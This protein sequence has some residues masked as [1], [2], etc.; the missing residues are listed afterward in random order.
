MMNISTKK[1]D[2]GE[3]FLANGQSISKADL[4]IEVI[5]D[6][7]ELNSW[8][9]VAVAYLDD[10]FLKDKKLLIKLQNEFFVMGAELAKAKKV[11]LSDQLLKNIEDRSEF[12]QTHLEESEYTKFVLPGGSKQAVWL[13]ISRTVCRRAERNLV[14]LNQVEKIR[15]ILLTTVNR[16]SDYLYVLRCYVNRELG[17]VEKKVMTKKS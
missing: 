8:I 5:G 11:K 10:K 3:T 4:R 14:K 9:G 15:P 17:I 13:D 16:L 12:L 2:K 1:G 6:L 7:D